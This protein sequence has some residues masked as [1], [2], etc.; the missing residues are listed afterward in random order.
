MESAGI[1]QRL[2]G[3]VIKAVCDYADSHKNKS[4]QD[5]AAATA[6]SATKALLEQYTPSD[7]PAATAPVNCESALY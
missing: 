5:Y 1:F 2:A 6:A 7:R 3:V 4:W